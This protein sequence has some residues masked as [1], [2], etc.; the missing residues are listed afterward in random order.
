MKQLGAT[1]VTIYSDSEL[2]VKQING[3]YKV[4]NSGLKILHTK[5]MNLLK[6]FDSFKVM[7]IPREKNSVADGLANR[8]IKEQGSR[9]K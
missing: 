7:H 1:R 4:K 6:E 5:V 8:A 3:S 9:R 2:V